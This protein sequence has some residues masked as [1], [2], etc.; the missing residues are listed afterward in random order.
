MS[1]WSWFF[2]ILLCIY[3]CLFEIYLLKKK[4][5]SLNSSNQESKTISPQE[6][7]QLEG[8]DKTKEVTGINKKIGELKEDIAKLSFD[9]PVSYYYINDQ[10]S[11]IIWIGL[12]GSISSAIGVYQTWWARRIKINMKLS[13]FLFFEKI[14]AFLQQINS[15][16]LFYIFFF[17]SRKI[18]KTTRDFRQNHQMAFRK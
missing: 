2:D 13:S 16:F 17:F 12:T 6:D 18:F 4:I 10:F 3:Y 9:L 5:Y 14:V 7:S 8:K 1:D 15:S 11:H